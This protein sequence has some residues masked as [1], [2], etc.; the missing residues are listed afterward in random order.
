MDGQRAYDLGMVCELAE[1]GRALETAIAL[2]ERI[3]ANAPLAV[4]HSMRI[5]RDA[6]EQSREE[7]WKQG[8]AAIRELSTTEDYREGPR[9]FVEKRAPVWRGR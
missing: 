6:G 2:A 5:L 3:N 1:P 4:R 9:A 8:R 7:T